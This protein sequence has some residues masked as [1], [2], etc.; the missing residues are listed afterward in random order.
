[1][2]TLRRYGRLRFLTVSKSRKEKHG[3]LCRPRQGAGAEGHWPPPPRAREV[4]SLHEL[5]AVDFVMRTVRTQEGD[6]QGGGLEG[7]RGVWG[8]AVE[9]KRTLFPKGGF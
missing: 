5:V 7:S 1:L 8:S 4:W 2:I 6:G 3:L 9:E